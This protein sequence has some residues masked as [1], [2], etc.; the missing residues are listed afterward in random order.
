MAAFGLKVA[1]SSFHTSIA[2]IFS[3]VQQAIIETFSIF[4]QQID[5]HF[6]AILNDIPIIAIAWDNVRTVSHP[7]RWDMPRVLSMAT[8]LG[9]AGVVSSFLFFY[10]L[11]EYMHYSKEVIQTMIFLKLLVAGHMTIFLTRTRAAFW[12]KP[13]P[14]LSL[15]IP[16]EITQI[17]GTLIAVYGVLITPI[18]WLNAGIAWGYALLWF[19]ILNIVK[20]IVHALQNKMKM[21]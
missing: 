21:R 16:L 20:I 14:S 19:F 18:G 9:L 8:M 12:D 3:L 1:L 7:V 13:F 6:R 4:E 17:V 5:R 15:F 10:G 2:K 11:R